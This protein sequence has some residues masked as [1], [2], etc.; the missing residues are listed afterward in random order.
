VL[1]S[2]P[3]IDRPP[4]PR[5]GQSSREILLAQRRAKQQNI[6][7]SNAQLTPLLS[8]NTR[9]LDNAQQRQGEYNLAPFFTN[10]VLTR[11]QT[12][13][14]DSLRSR[15]S[16]LLNLLVHLAPAAEAPIQQLLL[17]ATPAL[18]G[19]TVQL[20]PA[21]ETLLLPAPTSQILRIQR[22]PSVKEAIVIRKAH[23]FVVIAKKAQ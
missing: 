21:P 6:A 23:F 4:A 16:Q 20:Q 8:A 17:A 18:L 15:P 10:T 5:T 13:H 11:Y 3:A 9:S 14:H 22:P 7:V 12:P 19:L 2:K 1:S